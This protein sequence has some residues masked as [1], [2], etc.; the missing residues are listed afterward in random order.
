M[1]YI[2]LFYLAD[3]GPEK[4]E[5]G[6]FNSIKKWETLESLKVGDDQE[7]TGEPKNGDLKSKTR[8]KKVFPYL[9]L[10]KAGRDFSISCFKIK[11]NKIKQI[12]EDYQLPIKMIGRVTYRA[13]EFMMTT[14]TGDFIKI[15]V[16]ENS[17][18]NGGNFCSL[19]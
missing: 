2:K 4:F 8:E 16:S 18:L 3:C 9:F 7:D 14:Q 12:E 11:E 17:N 13:G 19:I 5:G 15:V 1:H 10:V 6:L